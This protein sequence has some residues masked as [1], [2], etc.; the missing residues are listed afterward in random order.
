MGY[1]ELST[2]PLHPSR[3]RTRKRMVGIRMHRIA[4]TPSCRCGGV[5]RGD[6]SGAG[7]VA[8]A[9]ECHGGSA[10]TRPRHHRSHCH[11]SPA[12]QPPAGTS[13]YQ[14]LSCTCSP[15]RRRSYFPPLASGMP[16]VQSGIAP[17]A[18][19]HPTSQ[20]PES[21]GRLAK[22]RSICS[23]LKVPRPCGSVRVPASAW[24]QKG[25][26]CHL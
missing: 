1:V 15:A 2:S 4:V 10:N 14:R 5:L 9:G 26:Y 22:R 17:Q 18:S 21:P 16:P 25:F 19:W 3:P 24:G 12:P 11:P 8:R 13:G 6:W 7:R 20:Q 23:P